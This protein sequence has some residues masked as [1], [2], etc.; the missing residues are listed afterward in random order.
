M[1]FF[2]IAEYDLTLGRRIEDPDKYGTLV[3]YI[4]KLFNYLDRFEAG[5]DAASVEQRLALAALTDESAESI[6]SGTHGNEIPALDA[7]SRQHGHPVQLARDP[8]DAP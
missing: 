8:P 4:K 5:D 1:S 6:R 3:F 7:T 2:L